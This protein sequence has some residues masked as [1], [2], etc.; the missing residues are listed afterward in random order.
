[1][2][3]PDF[4]FEVIEE[5]AEADKP[6]A[7]WCPT[8]GTVKPIEE[9]TRRPTILEANRWGW[10]R[11]RD[12]VYAKYT[13]RECNDCAKLRRKQATARA[14]DYAAYNEALF[15]TGQYEYLVHHPKDFRVMITKREHM[16]LMKR[17]ER[18]DIKVRKAKEAY[19]RRYANVYVNHLANLRRER[20]RIKAKIKSK[21]TNDTARAFCEMYLDYLVRLA[22]LI[23]YERK[24]KTVQPKE[25]VQEYADQGIRLMRE[26]REAW[27][28]LG[29]KDRDHIKAQYL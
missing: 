29:G 11:M 7:A 20:A 21:H 17:E 9:F 12:K 1:M 4:L 27:V 28:Q 24:T 13:G 2:E 6:E 18:R 22:E 15:K 23:E 5:Q 25:T 16:V 14:F 3:N 19:A 8:C 10:G 26:T